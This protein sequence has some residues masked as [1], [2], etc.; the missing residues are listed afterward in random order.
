MVMYRS[1]VNTLYPYLNIDLSHHPP[2]LV[3]EESG[4]YTKPRVMGDLTNLDFQTT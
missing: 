3:M 2:L 1:N 4:D